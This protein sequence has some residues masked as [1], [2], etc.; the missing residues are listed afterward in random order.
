MDLRLLLRGLVVLGVSAAAVAGLWLLANVI[1]PPPP[2][3]LIMATGGQSGSYYAIAERYQPL[4]AERGLT[5]TVR[6]TA[7]SLENLRLLQA[8]EVDIAFVQGGTVPADAGGLISICS[9][10]LEPLWLL[11]RDGQAPAY[12]SDLRGQRVQVGRAGSGTQAMVSMLFA[13]AGVA[14]VG[15]SLLQETA[16][17]EALSAGQVDAALLV[18]SPGSSSV[19]RMLARPGVRAVSLRRRD[20]LAQRH[21]FLAPV[22]LPEGVID[23]ADNLPRE[24]IETVAAA[25]AIVARSDL[26]PGVTAA[27]LRAATA[28]HSDGDLISAPGRFPAPDMVDAPLSED[29]RRYFEEGPSFLDRFLP[30]WLVS[31]INRLLIVTLPLVTLLLPLSRVAPPIYTWRNRSQIY[32]WYEQLRV[33]DLGLQQ[34]TLSP[35][36]ALAQVAAL[37]HE[38]LA[39]VNVPLSFMKEFYDLRLH[40]ELVEGRAR[41]QL[42]AP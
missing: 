21:P 28:V 41:E 26:H 27:I 25:A 30:L 19:R 32:R 6:E 39:E 8:G 16:D 5:L 1:A 11:A 2:Q 10:F 38:V 20:A 22:R 23:L 13:D 36:D 4:M 3:T 33:I 17:A 7:G 24:D 14:E 42:A 15:A 37:E 9:V 40:L 34:R 18:A 31:W 35:G 12:L 29:A